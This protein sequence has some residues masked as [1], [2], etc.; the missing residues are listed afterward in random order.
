MKEISRVTYRH[1]RYPNA[2][3][4]KSGP[5]DPTNTFEYSRA[6]GFIDD[7]GPISI[8]EP[9]LRGG[10]TVCMIVLDG[11]EGETRLIVGKANCSLSD[12]FVY[13]TGRMV[14]ASDAVSLMVWGQHNPRSREV[15]KKLLASNYRLDDH[16]AWLSDYMLRTICQKDP[17]L[18]ER[19]IDLYEHVTGKKW[20]VG[21]PL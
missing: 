20:N 17:G 15:T 21:K 11:D 13:E 1:W 2:P 19:I 16:G 14:A 18:Y 9:A 8:G 10:K 5:S 12:N 3:E 6:V 4:R 7:I